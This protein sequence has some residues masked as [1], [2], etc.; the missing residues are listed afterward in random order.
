[1]VTTE[2]NV[3]DLSTDGYLLSQRNQM[4][5]AV[6]FWICFIEVVEDKG[7]EYSAKRVFSVEATIL[8]LVISGNASYEHF[9]LQLVTA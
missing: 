1:M 4:I 3:L 2:K 6:D 7:V 9:P 8:V 5:T